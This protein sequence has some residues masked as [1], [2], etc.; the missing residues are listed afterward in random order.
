LT[1][2][3]SGVNQRYVESEVA[4]G[5]RVAVVFLLPGGL[6]ARRSMALPSTFM[7]LPVVDGDVSDVRPRDPAPGVVGLRWKIPH[8]KNIQLER[9]ENRAFVVPV[10]ELDGQLVAS[11]SARQ[12]PIVDPD[13]QEA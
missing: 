6:H 5:R 12:E 8:G 3:W 9:Q 10:A 13:T 1:F 4:R 2:S 7:G 11:Q